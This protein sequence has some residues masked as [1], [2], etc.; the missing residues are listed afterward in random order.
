MADFTSPK[1]IAADALVAKVHQVASR[2]GWI[3]RIEGFDVWFGDGVV[4]TSFTLA[5]LA[6]DFEEVFLLVSARLQETHSKHRPI[7][8]RPPSPVYG[9]PWHEY[10]LSG[11]HISEKSG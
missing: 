7:V 9:A 1:S 4:R 10:D 5:A 6:E 11:R 8:T 2:A 3:V